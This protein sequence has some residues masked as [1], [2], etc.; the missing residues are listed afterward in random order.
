MRIAFNA[1]GFAMYG[2]YLPDAVLGFG[3]ECEFHGYCSFGYGRLES[4]CFVIFNA[5]HVERAWMI[6]EHLSTTV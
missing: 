2:D 1:H 5:S 3:Y 6:E 4:I